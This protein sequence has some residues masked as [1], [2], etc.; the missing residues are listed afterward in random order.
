MHGRALIRCLPRGLPVSG[1]AILCQWGK[2]SPAG[3]TGW[4]CVPVVW[5][6]YSSGE[7]SWVFSQLLA[8]SLQVNS[9]RAMWAR[10]RCG[11]L[12]QDLF[13]ACREELPCQQFY[14]WCVFDA[15]G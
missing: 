7:G 5:R 14:E 4:K 10:K 11:V 1:S 15:C 8:S 2:S 3:R 6:G 9:H 13:A 12:L